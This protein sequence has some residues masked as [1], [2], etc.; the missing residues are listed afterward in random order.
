MVSL[1]L[2]VFL[3]KIFIWLCKVFVVACGMQDL[4][5]SAFKLLVAVC[6]I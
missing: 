4:L 2:G 1:Y 5:V 3:F 6:G